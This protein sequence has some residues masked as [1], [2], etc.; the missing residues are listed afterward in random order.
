M[1]AK[2]SSV[3]VCVCACGNSA[4]DTRP[5]LRTFHKQ[6]RNFDWRRKTCA[7]SGVAHVLADHNHGSVSEVFREM[8]CGL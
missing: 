5:S 2:T 4:C 6:P 3:G 7:G 1:F 8:R